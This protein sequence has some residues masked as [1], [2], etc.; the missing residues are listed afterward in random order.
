MT[1][2]IKW[3]FRTGGIEEAPDYV[4]DNWGQT[5]AGRFCERCWKFI[6]AQALHQMRDRV[7]QEYA[8]K[9]SAEIELPN[10]VYSF[11]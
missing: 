9:K 1:G 8:G 2:H 11:I 5:L 6:A 4:D 7:G 3:K 10:H